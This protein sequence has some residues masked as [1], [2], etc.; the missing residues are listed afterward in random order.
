M[1]GIP[2]VMVNVR[3]KRKEMVKSSGINRWEFFLI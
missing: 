3:G 2:E 1:M